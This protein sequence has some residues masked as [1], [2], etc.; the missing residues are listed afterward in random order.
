MRPPHPCQLHRMLMPCQLMTLAE[1]SSGLAV[2]CPACAGN[3]AS[4]RMDNLLNSD[5]LVMFVLESLPLWY[6]PLLVGS[7]DACAEM[8]GMLLA[9][10]W[11]TSGVTDAC[12]FTSARPT[13]GWQL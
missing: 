11:L 1:N 4:L 6:F 3:C 2:V 10:C 9:L 12:L 5:A 7:A 8:P 13:W